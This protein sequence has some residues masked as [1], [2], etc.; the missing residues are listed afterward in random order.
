MP[1]ELRHVLYADDEADIL[2]VASLA[3]EMV[4]GLEVTACPGGSEAIAAAHRH[5]PDLILLDVMMPVMDGP[6]TLAAIRSDPDLAAIPVVLLTARI[7]RAEVETYLAAG[8]DGVIAKPFNPMTL[9]DEVRA[10]WCHV[11]AER[12]G[13]AAAGGYSAASAQAAATACGS[14]ASIASGVTGQAVLPPLR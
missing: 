8:A 9:A 6:A 12:A 11:R 7:R 2:S 13:A 1:D 10:V 5:R 3:L 4:G 14:N